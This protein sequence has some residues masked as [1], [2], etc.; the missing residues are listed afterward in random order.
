M[1]IPTE[2][3]DRFVRAC[4]RVAANGL[5]RCSIGNLSWRLDDEHMLITCGRSW[6][7]E[8]ERVHV[9][10]CRI[11][12]GTL[13]EGPRPSAETPLHAG[14]LRC[15]E[16]VYVVLHSQTPWATAA[17]CK[18]GEAVNASVIPEIPYYI[19]PIAE[20]PYLQPGS[21]ELAEAVASAAADHDLVQLRNH[22][23]VVVG[24]SFDDVIQKAAFFELACEIIVR[25]GESV[26]PL[27]QEEVNAL[28]ESKRARSH[29]A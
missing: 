17:G 16:D 4:H 28:L 8:M 12:S 7:G 22:G 15:R 20:V 19:G 3:L 5:V 10:Q 27:P 23:Q 6:M 21:T 14:V 11:D 9:S 1:Q 18:R 2:D 24:D 13:V 29:G 25:G 26:Q